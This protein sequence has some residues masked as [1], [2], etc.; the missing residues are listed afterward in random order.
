MAVDLVNR[1]FQTFALVMSVSTL[2][3]HSAG[4]KENEMA[5]NIR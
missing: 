2:P 4:S 5:V 3:R 1:Y